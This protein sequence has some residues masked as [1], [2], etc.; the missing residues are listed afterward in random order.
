MFVRLI[1]GCALACGLIAA[2]AGALTDPAEARMFKGKTAQGYRIKLAV[3]DRKFKILKFEAD[4]RCGDG[5][6]LTLI[7][8]GFLW[9]PVRRNGNFRDAQFGR[10][11]SVYFRGRVDKRRLGGRVRLTDKLRGGLRCKSRWIRFNAQPRR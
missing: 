11:D 9:T 10:T 7:E 8:S 1:A 6:T 3:K 2:D 5:G 4:L